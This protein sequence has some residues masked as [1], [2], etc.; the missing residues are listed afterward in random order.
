MD[1]DEGAVQ[2][3]GFEL[4]AEDLRVLQ[5]GKD[6]IQDP[7][8]RPPV[9]ARIDGVPVAEPLGQA[10][11]FAPL[12]GDVQNSVEHLQIVKRHVAAWRRQTRRD[13][14]ILGV[15]DF[16]ARSIA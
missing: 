9:H 11:P 16:H 14:A 3:H 15:G 8:L 7:A 4:Y 12:L 10:A 2:G 13:V 5:L 6:A 1:L